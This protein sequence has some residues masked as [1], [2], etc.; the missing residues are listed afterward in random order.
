MKSQ[1][2]GEYMKPRIS[3]VKSDKDIQITDKSL[4]MSLRVMAGSHSEKK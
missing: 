1:K 2:G 3:Q 4:S